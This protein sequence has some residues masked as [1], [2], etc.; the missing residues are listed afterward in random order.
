M[1]HFKQLLENRVLIKPDA[2]AQITEGGI[3][4]PDTAKQR[5]GK[6]T[7]LEVGEGFVIKEGNLA[8]T[9]ITMKVHVGDRVLFD[10]DAGMELELDKEKV[11]MILETPG[12]YGVI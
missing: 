2:A 3:I 12:V 8:G 9:T 10:P 11:I 4:I 7:V 5:V 1:Q 6:G